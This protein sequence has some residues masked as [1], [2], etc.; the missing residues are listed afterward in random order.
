MMSLSQNSEFSRHSTGEPV[1]FRRAQILEVDH[2]ENDD[3][4]SAALTIYAPRTIAL[5]NQN[6][7]TSKRSSS[8][9]YPPLPASTAASSSQGRRIKRCKTALACLDPCCPCSINAV[10]SVRNCPCAIAGR[11]CLNCDPGN[12]K[13]RNTVEAV[14]ERIDD[15]NR[16][17]QC[18][19]S[20]RRMRA[21]LGIESPPLLC[22]LAPLDD[23]NHP[24]GAGNQEDPSRMEKTKQHSPKWATR[25]LL[26][27]MISMTGQRR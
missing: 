26:S 13:C 15:H 24:A 1:E 18:G 9:A 6:R 7:P 19:S 17:T 3:E 12:D 25:I 20:S 27:T 21:F 2:H 11:P 14:N 22:H 8:P 4:S 23:R 10:C 16:R 5:P